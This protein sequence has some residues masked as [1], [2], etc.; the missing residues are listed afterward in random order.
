[1]SE[2][3]IIQEATRRLIALKKK[4]G[5]YNVKIDFEGLEWTM[6]LTTFDGKPFNKKKVNITC[7]CGTREKLL[8]IITPKEA[9][10]TLKEYNE[11]R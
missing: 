11:Y 6:A 2:T 3:Q 9:G 10:Y 7:F 1:M 4:S 5:L 8:N